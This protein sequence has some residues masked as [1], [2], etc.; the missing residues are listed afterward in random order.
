MLGRTNSRAHQ[1]GRA[2]KRAR[3]QYDF[4]RRDGLA[5]SQFNSGGALPVNDYVVH[6]RVSA[7]GQVRAFAHFIGEIGHPSVYTDPVDNVQRIVSDT[8]WIWSIEIGDVGLSHRLRGIDE[9]F[10]LEF[11]LTQVASGR[12]ENWAG[13]HCYVEFRI[14]FRNG[15]R[16]LWKAL[17]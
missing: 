5:G 14:L 6:L 12:P 4:S 16:V 2:S 13:R 3:C 7:N 15:S 10:A 9:G 17:Y 11:L 1:D 8:L